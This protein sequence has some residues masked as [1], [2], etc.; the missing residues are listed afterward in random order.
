MWKLLCR[1]AIFNH[2]ILWFGTQ[3]YIYTYIL[4]QF[5]FVCGLSNRDEQWAVSMD[6]ILHWHFNSCCK[7][8]AAATNESSIC[9]CT[10]FYFQLCVCVYFLKHKCVSGASVWIEFNGR[11]YSAFSNTIDITTHDSRTTIF[12]EFVT[13][14]NAIAFSLTSLGSP[15][16]ICL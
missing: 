5:L 4:L 16:R 13:S 2:S 15:L 1:L 10:S 11:P 6:S 9:S 8:D 3:I 7:I 14:A 12:V